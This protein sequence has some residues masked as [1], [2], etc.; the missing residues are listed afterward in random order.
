MSELG[1]KRPFCAIRMSSALSPHNGHLQA[2]LALPFCAKSRNQ[3]QCAINP[4]RSEEID[5]SA[6]ANQFRHSK[7]CGKLNCRSSIKAAFTQSIGCAALN[8]K[9]K[10]LS[11]KPIS[12]ING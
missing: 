1:H 12:N 7:T 3:R 11:L 8:T 9:P 5:F 2:R 4:S 10:R 6:L